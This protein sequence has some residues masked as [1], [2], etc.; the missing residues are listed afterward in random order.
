M[1]FVLLPSVFF[2]I[3]VGRIKG[4]NF[5]LLFKTRIITLFFSLIVL[6]SF[7]M[8]MRNK[9]RGAD[10]RD[11]EVKEF[12]ERERTREEFYASHYVLIH[13]SQII[14]K[15]ISMPRTRRGIVEKSPFIYK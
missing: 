8:E 9:R 4:A 10:D 2:R 6:K 15:S 11:E 3:H 14:I 13:A 12:I 7:K 5:F 1:M